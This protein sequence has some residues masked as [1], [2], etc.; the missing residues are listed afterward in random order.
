LKQMVTDG[1]MAVGDAAHQADPLTAGGIALGLMGAD[2]AMQVAV[3]AVKRGDVSTGT[4]REY[5]KLWRGRF[6]KMHDALYAMRKIISKMEQAQFDALVRKAASLPL[7][8][9][10]QAEILLS[11]LKS[12]PS[13]LL[14]ART[15]VT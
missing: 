1:L 12:Q 3:P 13:L 5:E 14:Q 7:E 6:G 2:M 10:S 8:T 11:L 9:M 4:L 15:L